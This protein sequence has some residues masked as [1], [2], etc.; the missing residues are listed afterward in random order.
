MSAI[1]DFFKAAAGI[2]QT[3]LL[4]S[5]QWSLDRGKLTLNPDEI[6]ELGKS[7]GAVHMKGGGLNESVLV[8]R[9][10]DDRFYAFSNRCTHMGRRLDPAPG[11]QKLRCCSVNHATYSFDGAKLSGP[12]KGPVKVYPVE[13]RDGTLIVSL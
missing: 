3:P 6:P 7:G 10:Q 12:A 8:V 9:G 4:S 13:Q 11:E 5:E 1:M 2:C